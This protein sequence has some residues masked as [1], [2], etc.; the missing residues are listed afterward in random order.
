M[1]TTEAMDVPTEKIAHAA[2]ILEKSV[3]L[4]LSCSYLG[5]NRKV[6][7]EQLVEEKGGTIAAADAAAFHA[8][9]RLLDPKEL[10]DAMRITGKVKARL[11][12]M[13]ISTHRVFGERSYLIPLALVER[14][15]ADLTEFQAQLRQ[16][17]EALGARYDAAVERQK[18]RLGPQFR[19]AD[20][21]GA[22]AV[23]EAFAIDWSYV[24]F[25][26]PDR[27]ETV[28]HVLAENAQRKHQDR[29]A[30]AFDEVLIGL[31]ASALE[32][33]T[34]LEQ[35][36][37]P[38]DERPKAKAIRGTA[39]RDLQEF[40]ALLPH[41]NITGDDELEAVMARIAA[42][43]DGLDVRMLRDSAFVRDGLWQAVCEAKAALKGL[44]ETGRRAI[45]FGRI[46][47]VA[48]ERG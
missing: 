2:T 22:Q 8:T 31:R 25:A 27:L 17:A 35:R 18:E 33:M 39:L 30:A 36:L 21:V 19:A 23:V 14:V 6:D 32:V 40:Q 28:S 5:N 42:R 46:E 47:D 7:L 34:D 26:A 45:T 11:R 13:A 10:R 29:L 41:R 16:E 38:D 44:V 24:S 15:D 4:T 43:A 20:Y 12:S 48:W 3:C 1:T 9:K 37:A